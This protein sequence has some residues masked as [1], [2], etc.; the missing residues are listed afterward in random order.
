MKYVNLVTDVVYILTILTLFTT[1]LMV[2]Y[3]N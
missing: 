2:L 3:P 1:I